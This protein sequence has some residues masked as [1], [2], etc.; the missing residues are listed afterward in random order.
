MNT[1]RDGACPP[2]ATYRVQ[3]VDPAGFST[4]RIHRL[5]HNFHLHPLL[6]LPELANL[7]GELMPSGQCRFVHPRI[8]QDSAF[9]H[10]DQ[11]PDGRDLDEV[12]QRIEEPGSWIALYNIETIPRYR[13]LLD[14]IL[15]TVRPIIERE[16]PGIFNL[17]GFCFISAPPSVTPFHIDRENNFWLQLHGRKILTVWDASDRGAVPADAVEDFIV[18]HSSKKVR[19]TDAGRNSGHAFDSGPGDGVYF[20]TT[21]PHT[22]RSDEGWTTPG[23]GVSVSLGVTFYTSHTRKLARVH[24]TNRVLRKYLRRHPTCPGQSPALD[25]AKSP[26]GWMLAVTRH[27]LL[28]QLHAFRALRSG[29]RPEAGWWGEKAPPGSY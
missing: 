20:P 10:I 12:F 4:F 17:T 6:Q 22:T 28:R 3:P 25:A 15:D 21:S 18:K 13:A 7:A 1:H 19:M 5:R 27:F 14:D 24:Q 16:Q 23:N 29:T 11:H 8:A 2:D 9:L 26:L